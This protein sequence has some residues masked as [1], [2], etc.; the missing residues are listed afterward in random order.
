MG[1]LKS[2]GSI[3]AAPSLAMTQGLSSI[4]GGSDTLSG[5]ASGLPFVGQG[6]ANAQAQKFNASQAGMQMAFQERMSSTA[7][8][9]EVADLKKAGLNPILSAGGQ[10]ASSPAGAAAHISPLS[11]AS[12]SASMLNSIYRKER[13]KAQTEIDL[14]KQAKQTAK[15]QEGSHMNSAKKAKSETEIL[16]MQKEAVRE[17][18]KA[19]AIKAKQDAEYQKV[20]IPKAE[21]LQDRIQPAVTSAIGLKAGMSA[22]K[23][24]TELLKGGRVRDQLKDKGVL[25]SGRSKGKYHERN[26]NW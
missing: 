19:K 18:A 12:D 20:R 3:I 21:Y 22:L 4:V 10:G 11:G 8:Q 5:Y 23:N 25:D 17:E 9:R 15:A 14:N 16:N 7:H 2:I 1:F 26:D 6:F 13:T 24:A